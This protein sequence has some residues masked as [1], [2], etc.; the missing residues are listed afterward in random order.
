MEDGDVSML[1]EQDIAERV[2]DTKTRQ[3]KEDILSSV[4]S[5]GLVNNDKKKEIRFKA[6]HA[7][8]V[9]FLTLILYVI[10]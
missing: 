10:L 1:K 6:S 5:R 4:Q 3:D 8:L 2:V 9:A 7:L